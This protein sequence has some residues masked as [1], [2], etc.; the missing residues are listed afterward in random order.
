MPPVLEVK[1][2][3]KTFTLKRGL[4]KRK[5]LFAVNDVS[6]SVNEGEFFSIV[7]ESGSGKTTIARLILRLLRPD[8]GEILF[9]GKDIFTMKREELKQYRKR[10]QIVFQNPFTSFNPLMKVK[11]IIME[12]LEIHSIGTRKEREEKVKQAMEL[13]N[14]PLSFLDRF[15]DQLSGGQR[16]RI[17]I[18]RSI[19][20]NP[21]IIVADEPVSSL[22]VSI[23]AQIVNLF[24]RLHKDLGITFIFIAHDINLVRHLS[25]RVV[26][27]YKGRVVDYGE[28]G[29]VFENPESEFTMKLIKSLPPIEF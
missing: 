14:L 20:V 15:P 24:L 2:L 27:M 11:N 26:V 1:N 6:F 16:Q 29:K 25:D 18:A 13:V 4:F 3:V 7:G 19:V 12:P 28:T 5:K 22:D 9:K 10:V 17:G 23:Q 8:R 21:D